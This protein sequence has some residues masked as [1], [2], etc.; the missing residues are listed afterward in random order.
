MEINR[1]PWSS[2]I[3][4]YWFDE[5]GILHGI[6]KKAPRTLDALK[7]N[8]D[9]V[10][11]IT[12]GRK[13]CFLVDNT[14]TRAYAIESLMYLLREFSQSYKAVAFVSRSAIGKAVGAISAE[15]NP[16]SVPIEVFD[17]TEEAIEWLRSYNK[18]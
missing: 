5:E 15:L 7:E 17:S 4:D 16:D 13:V 12:G 6:T 11:E 2:S 14:N 3:A 9:L 10:H 18:R 8:F 1:G